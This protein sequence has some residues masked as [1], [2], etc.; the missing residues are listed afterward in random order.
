MIEAY[1]D[2]PADLALL[3]LLDQRGLGVAGRRLGLVA[4]G[5]ER[6]GA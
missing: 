6:R 2:G 4:R 5:A 1:V 3:E